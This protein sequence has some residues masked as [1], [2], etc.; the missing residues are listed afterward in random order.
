MGRDDSSPNENGPPT[1]GTWGADHLDHAESWHWD[2]SLPASEHLSTLPETEDAVSIPPMAEEESELE[3]ELESELPS[4]AAAQGALRAAEERRRS[5]TIARKQMLRERRRMIAQGS[6]PEVLEY[7][8][9]RT[10]E[11]C[12][13]GRRPCLYV[14]C[15]Y[16]LYLDVNP[17]TGSI[18]L[19]FPDLEVKDLQETCALD[20]A[21]RGGITLEEVGDIM[22]LTRERIRQVEV[23]G[24]DKLRSGEADLV[25]FLDGKELMVGGRTPVGQ[26]RLPVVDE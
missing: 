21:E 7:E 9:P 4:P 14:S 3:P 2:S 18:K 25:T 19:N 24:L 22:N 10:R 8:R 12:R 15:R 6:L 23:S 16:H 1:R 5:R 17:T 11:Q 20:V 13:Q 26:A